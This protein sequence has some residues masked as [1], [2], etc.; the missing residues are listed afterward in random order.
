MVAEHMNFLRI[1]HGFTDIV[2]AVAGSTR[3]CAQERGSRGGR[4]NLEMGL[5]TKQLVLRERL[6]VLKTQENSKALNIG[7][8]V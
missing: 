2:E 3:S 6:S 5:R 1:A 8:E 7:F 4:T